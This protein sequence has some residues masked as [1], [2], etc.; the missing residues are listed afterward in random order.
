M[1]EKQKLKPQ[2][3][4]AQTYPAGSIITPFHQIGRQVEA[5]GF[6]ILPII[7]EETLTL[8]KLPFQHRDPFDRIIIVQSFTNGLT[9][10]SRGK[11]F[12]QCNAKVIW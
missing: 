6:E 11:N 9:V 1:R 7:F 12:D 10:I 5:N 8:S 3:T 2:L 4:D